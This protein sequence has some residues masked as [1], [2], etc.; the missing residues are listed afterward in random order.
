MRPFAGS[1]V[2]EPHCIVYLHF[3]VVIV[4]NIYDIFPSFDVCSTIC[5]R[6]GP[7]SLGLLFDE[8]NASISKEFSIFSPFFDVIYGPMTKRLPPE[9]L[10]RVYWLTIIIVS[11]CVVPFFVRFNPD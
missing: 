2:S 1:T 10:L 5:V 4:V 6:V 7:C 8:V 11:V 3:I 9:C